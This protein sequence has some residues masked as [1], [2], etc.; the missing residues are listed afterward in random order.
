M[1]LNKFIIILLIIIV[2]TEIQIC[3]LIDAIFT[4]FCQERDSA[5]SEA[6]AKGLQE[7]KAQG[8]E[9]AEKPS[10]NV[11]EEVSKGLVH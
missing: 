11:N 10:V 7:G 1:A 3:Q 4:C 8:D 5:V 6:Y 2:I 9:N